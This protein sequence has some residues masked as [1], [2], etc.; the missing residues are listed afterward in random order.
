MEGIPN[1]VSDR[2]YIIVG[3]LGVLFGSDCHGSVYTDGCKQDTL[4]GEANS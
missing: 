3:F 2:L 4:H 1:K